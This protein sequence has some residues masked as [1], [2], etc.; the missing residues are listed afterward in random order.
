[1]AAGDYLAKKKRT[2]ANL[3]KFLKG[4]AILD[5]YNFM[6]EASKPELYTGAEKNIKKQLKKERIG[7]GRSIGVQEC[8]TYG[9]V[10]SIDPLCEQTIDFMWELVASLL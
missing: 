8:I 3:L 6:R 9:A 7:E 5:L 4:P 10:E 2:K 1:M